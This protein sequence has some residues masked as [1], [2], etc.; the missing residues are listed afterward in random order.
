[1]RIVIH[2]EEIATRRV[3]GDMRALRPP[4]IGEVHAHAGDQ[5]VGDN[6][7]RHIVDPARFKRHYN[8]FRFTK[9]GHENDGHMRKPLHAL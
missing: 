1:M 2:G 5:H 8:V 3:E 9:S 7:L 4:G 6:R